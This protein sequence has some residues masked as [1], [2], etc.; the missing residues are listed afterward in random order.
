VDVDALLKYIVVDRA[1][2]NWDGIMS[3]YWGSNHNYF[4]Y[5]MADG[6]WAL[7]PWDMDKTF[8]EYDRFFDP[9]PA[10]N[11]TTPVPG[12]NVYPSRCGLAYPDNMYSIVETIGPPEEGPGN[13][14]FV[15]PGC[16]PLINTLA[17]LY[18]DDF[19]AH[20]EAFLD[21][22]FAEDNLND[23]IDEWS[24][25]IDAVM[26]DEPT[27]SYGEW[28][29]AVTAL[30]GHLPKLRSDFAAHLTDTYREE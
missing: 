5:H 13:L 10:E 11:I 15:A 14:M 2:H 28:Q 3:F 27:I 12:W 20:G 18:W 7:I 22:A 24:A 4:W 6:R 21:G 25:Q 29:A 8:F 1:I 30:R 23:L 26:Q 9:D 19:V 17:A 16:D